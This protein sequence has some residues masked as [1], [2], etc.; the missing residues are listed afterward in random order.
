MRIDEP[1]QHNLPT[2]I[3][4][5]KLFSILFEPRIAERFFC[6]ADGNDLAASTKDRAVFDDGE[7]LQTSTAA[8]SSL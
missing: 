8:R 2:A 3:N 4:F 7:F 6:C 1:R 5:Q